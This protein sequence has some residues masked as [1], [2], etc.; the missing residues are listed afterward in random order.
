[1]DYFVGES[2]SETLMNILVHSFL[3]WARSKRIH[4]R[5]IIWSNT[6]DGLFFLLASRIAFSIRP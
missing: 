4:K 6:L 1:M 3:F 5:K 2:T